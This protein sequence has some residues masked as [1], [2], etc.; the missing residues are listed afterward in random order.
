M[1]TIIELRVLRWH[2]ILSPE[3]VRI[4]P[5]TFTYVTGP[6]NTGCG[7]GYGA[8]YAY[9]FGDGTTHGDQQGGGTG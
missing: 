3:S 9:P 8:T 6:P 5:W 4:V 7:P 2:L 1:A